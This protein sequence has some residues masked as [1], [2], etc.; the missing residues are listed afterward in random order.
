MGISTVERGEKMEKFK[1]GQLVIYE[2]G[3]LYEVGKIKAMKGEEYA[4][5]LYHSG[6]TSA[7]THISN[8]H[9]IR[10]EHNLKTNLGGGI[11]Y[12]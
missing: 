5:L 8:L 11:V 10:N 3:Y 12:E 7:L 9:P 1:V 6:E 4:F 2:N